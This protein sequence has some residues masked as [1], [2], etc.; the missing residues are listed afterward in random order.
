[1]QAIR[2]N[3]PAYPESF[4][5]MDLYADDWSIQAVIEAFQEQPIG[6]ESLCADL[7]EQMGYFEFFLF[8]MMYWNHGY[9]M[10]KCF[11][12]AIITVVALMSIIIF[13]I[14]LLHVITS[15]C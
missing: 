11:I 14:L 6:F 1:M 8:F 4:Y 10:S 9:K 12:Y 15:F 5:H 7:L 3:M 13:G 2:K